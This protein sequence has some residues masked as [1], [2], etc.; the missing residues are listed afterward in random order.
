MT[1]NE[2]YYKILGVDKNDSQDIIKQKFKQLVK[3]WHPDKHKNDSD[4]KHAEQIFKSIVSAYEILS[5]PEKRKIYDNQGIDGLNEIH[6]D[7]DLR[8][9]FEKFFSNISMNDIFENESE[10]VVDDCI[11]SINLTLEELYTGT[12]KEVEIERYSICKKCEGTGTKSKKVESC[13]K[14]NGCGYIP[15][16]IGLNTFA[17]L[18]CKECGVTGLDKKLDRCKKCDGI[19]YCKE[20]ISID[21]DIPVGAYSGYN[22][23]I[24][25]QGHIIPLD[26]VENKKEQRSKIVVQIN[27]YDHNIFKRG[28]FVNYQTNEID[29]ANLLMELNIKFF[30]SMVGFERKIKKLNGEKLFIKYTE[31]TRHDDVLVFI[32][33][34]MPKIDLENEY[35]DLFIKII[36]E[37][38][39]NLEFD[40][41]M[42]QNI[43]KL[44]DE[45]SVKNT[46][47]SNI[48]N[49]MMYE[50]H[51]KK[52]VD[53]HK[54]NTSQNKYNHM[55]KKEYIL[56]SSSDEDYDSEDN[57]N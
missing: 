9:I 14:C 40:K 11:N 50:K 21:I 52:L 57:E 46:K 29:P 2:D 30:E 12:T 13:K 38:P 48:I 17:E 47:K 16:K 35:G 23:V 53:K 56:E 10:L 22:I 42:K 55:K 54:K 33:Q 44:F 41:N 37:H 1:N 3:Q 49:L 31:P 8:D 25:N 20:T 27:E 4:K 39:A 5:D 15:T 45:E 28:C 26:E 51:I 34:G 19:K 36:V 7:F 32:G 24:P 6:H 43:C 18:P